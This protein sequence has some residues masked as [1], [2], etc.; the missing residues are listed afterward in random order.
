MSAPSYA[1]EP[2]VQYLHQVL[3][4]IAKGELEIP[5]FQRPDRWDDSQRQSLLDSVSRGY[6]I[7][8]VMVWR[9]TTALATVRTIGDRRLRQGRIEGPRQ[10]LLDGMQRLSTLFAALW[11]PTRGRSDLVEPCKSSPGTA[12]WE[13]GYHLVNEEWVFLDEIDADEQKLVVPGQSLYSNVE[14]L[15]FQR[16]IEHDRADELVERADEVASA[17]REY[18]IAVLPLVSDS[19]EEAARTFGL[20]NSQG[21]EMSAIDLIHALTWSKSWS[22][23]NVMDQ[24]KDRLRDIGWG[25]LE[26]KYILAVIRAALGLD[27]YTG[28]AQEVSIGLR[29]DKTV[30]HRSMDGIHAAAIF[31]QKPCDVVS[32]K[33]LPYS[34]QAVLL[35]DVLH[36]HPKPSTTLLKEL[37]RWFWW[38][39]AWATFA[40]IS[41]YRL[42][43]MVRYLRDLAAEK[44]VKWLRKQP[45]PT[46]LPATALPNSARIHALTIHLY[47]QQGRPDA[48]K[49]RLIEE[50]ARALMRGLIG[51]KLL[52]DPGNHFLCEREQEEA[53]RQALEQRRTSQEALPLGSKLKFDQDQRKRHAISDRAWELLGQGDADAFI[54]ERRSTLEALELEFLET[55][56]RPAGA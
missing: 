26:E 40:G 4:Q 14:L 44:P 29:D 15:R 8:A 3:D 20:I 7:G 17:L 21:T 28:T 1:S 36:R 11:A 42:T 34:Y 13:L 23:R 10:Y 25:E 37:E 2:Q 31:L 51:C 46:P 53:L 52:R 27:I 43:G 39:T 49:S 55:L 56:G 33:L 24:A 9:T 47:R 6:P 54:R 30:V 16:H 32:L 18:K 22:L 41:G 48:I 12:R 35:A 50:G 45:K 19:V 38:T 5:D